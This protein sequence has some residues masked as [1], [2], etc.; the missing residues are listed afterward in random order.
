MVRRTLKSPSVLIRKCSQRPPHSRNTTARNPSCLRQKHGLQIPADLVRRGDGCRHARSNILTHQA[1]FGMR[2]SERRTFRARTK[3][4]L[5]FLT[6][7]CDFVFLYAVDFS[8]Q[9]WRVT[10]RIKER[11]HFCNSLS[12][13]VKIFPAHG[14]GKR[15]FHAN[16]LRRP[17]DKGSFARLFFN[18]LSRL[19]SRQS[20]RKDYP[21][22]GQL[23]AI[24]PAN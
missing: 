10:S 22:V 23:R 3:S 8:T 16:K 24:L 15:L 12:A 7:A 6:M 2:K 1:A 21:L 9:S 17:R 5:Y 19:V 14:R 4:V 20:S 11:E 13:T 18:P